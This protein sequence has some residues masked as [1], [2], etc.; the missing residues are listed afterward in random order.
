M[1]VVSCMAGSC[2]YDT[3]E[4]AEDRENGIKRP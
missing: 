3:V 1:Y 4:E 2:F